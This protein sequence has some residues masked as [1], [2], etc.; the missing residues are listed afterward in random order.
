MKNLY[1]SV[2]INKVIL[3]EEQNV[4]ECINYYKLK[5]RKYGLEIVKQNG[6]NEEKVEITNIANITDNEEKINNVLNMLVAKEIMPSSSDIIE[7][8][9]K[10]YV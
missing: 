1:G 9:L 2:K 4:E 7:D 3:N 6:T 10:Q 8:L 5:N